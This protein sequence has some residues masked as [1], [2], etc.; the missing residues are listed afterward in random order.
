MFGEGG[1][2]GAR[3]RRQKET[4]GEGKT[5]ERQEQETVVPIIDGGE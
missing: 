5:A 2:R 3:E 4:E 1:V